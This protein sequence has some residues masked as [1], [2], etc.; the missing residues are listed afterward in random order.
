VI[1]MGDEIGMGENLEIPDRLSV[2]V[3]MQWSAAPSGGFS[4][5]DPAKL[6]RPMADGRFGPRH[7]NVAAQRRDPD[8]LLNWM[9][10]LIRRRKET[11][12]LGWGSST[13]IETSARAVFAHRCDWQGSTVVAVHNLSGGKAKATLDLGLVKGERAELDDLLEQRDHRPNR[14]GT[15]DVELD[16]YGYVW[17]R[18]RR[19]GERELS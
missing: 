4:S 6:V 3:P 14:D 19:G 2:R 12:E 8:S 17:L 15:L 7:V 10:R 11:P 9:E 18:V 16:G 1:F 13:L 5:A